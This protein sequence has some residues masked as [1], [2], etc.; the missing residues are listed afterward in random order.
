MAATRVGNR[1]QESIGRLGNEEGKVFRFYL[2]NLLLPLR[3]EKGA[4]LAEYGLLLGLIALVAVGAVTLLGNQIST[5]FNGIVT[6][7]T[8]VP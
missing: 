3:D 4:D 7:L 1:G 8:G 2:R 6:A 5:V